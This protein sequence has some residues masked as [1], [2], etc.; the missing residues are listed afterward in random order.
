MNSCQEKPVIEISVAMS[1]L[2]GD[3]YII[4]SP[5]RNE[6]NYLDETIR[7][8]VSQSIRPVLYILVDDGSTDTTLEIIEKWA[9][10]HQWIV[11]VHKAA[12]L[13]GSAE[14]TVEA[15]H[16][17][18]M[19]AREAK[20]IIAFYYGLDHAA[21]LDVDFIVKLDGDLGFSETYFESCFRHFKEDPTLGVGGGSIVHMLNDKTVV[22]RNPAFHVRGA[23]KIY[24]KAC[25]DAIGGVARGAGWDTLDEV[26][27]NML[28]FKSMSFEELQVIHYR[29]TGAA[30][31][32][33]LNAV[34][35]GEWNYLSGYHPIFMFF[36]CLRNLF[37][38]PVMTGSLGLSYGYLSALLR[39]V[40]RVAEPSLIRYIRDQQL[41]R[42]SFRR[43][44]WR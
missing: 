31:G 17:R 22:E 32:K 28:G 10:L 20:E 44:I 11:P 33:W 21:T 41:R 16:E 6:G 8:V 43:T 30:N 36:K 9:S 38:R 14:P 19:R 2:K 1:R 3:R 5:V 42:L 4:V 18:G 29:Y 24:T 34:K 35:K 15:S 12:T 27:A 37:K 13:Q 23:T 25:W 26:K 39:R 40:N 7:C